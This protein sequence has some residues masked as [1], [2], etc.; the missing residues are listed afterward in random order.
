M[1]LKDVLE[2]ILFSAQKPLM[3]KELS[4]ICADA[5]EHG[6]REFSRVKAREINE[7]LET[8]QAEHEAAGRTYRLTCVAEAWQFTSDQDYAPWIKALVGQ[9][10]RAPRLSKPALETLAIISYRQ[11]LTRA[12]MEEIRGVSVDGVIGTLLERDLVEVVGRADAPGRPQT[13]GTTQIFLE[14]FGLRSLEELPNAEE[15]QQIPITRPEAP[16]TTGEDTSDDE[17][18]QMSLEEVTAD[19]DKAK[20]PSTDT[21]DAGEEEEDEDEF[22]DEDDD[23]DDD[24]DAGEPAPE[25]A[26]QT[27]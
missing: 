13:Y 5:A 21:D 25:G 17:P 20:T 12:E 16:V 14:Y 15:L 23:D 22:V 24:E 7:A 4:A 18:E 19:N 3:V 1:E 9:K 26:R 6:G 8:L 2:S 10:Q 27:S 11:P